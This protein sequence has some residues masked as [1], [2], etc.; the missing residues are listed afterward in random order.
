MASLSSQSKLS[1]PPATDRGPSLRTH[2]LFLISTLTL[3]LLF[4]PQ[5]PWRR[6]RRAGDA[7]TG[8]RW[9]PV[10]VSTAQQSFHIHHK[11]RLK[12]S[13]QAFFFFLTSKKKGEKKKEKT[14]KTSK[15]LSLSHPHTPAS[16]TLLLMHYI[17]IC[18]VITLES[19]KKKSHNSPELFTSFVFVVFCFFFWLSSLS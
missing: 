8:S 4:L 11:V 1:A 2:N 17:F 16:P 14:Q 7:L 5:L 15:L 10:E 18:K 19:S 6:L 3:L 9:F 13:A 12:L